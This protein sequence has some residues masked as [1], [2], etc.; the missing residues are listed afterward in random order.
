M[1]W[2]RLVR[3]LAVVLMTGFVYIQGAGTQRNDM[4]AFVVQNVSEETVA[5][6]E[7]TVLE[8]KSVSKER[9]AWGA[10]PNQ[11]GRF[12]RWSVLGSCVRIQ[13]DGHYGSGSIYEMT[14]DQIIIITNRHVLQYWD[15]DSYVTFSNGV[16]CEGEIAKVSDAAD[17][18]LLRIQL[19]ELSE[20][21]IKDLQTIKITDVIPEKGDYF[22]MIDMASDVWDKQLYEG[23]IL[24]SELYIEEFDMEMLYG[25]ACFEPG[26]SG[27][28]IFDMQGNYIG[29]LTGGTQQN[30]VAAVPAWSIFMK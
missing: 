19:T 12:D 14:E 13:T 16:V 5:L 27:C 2:K 15:E 18:G 22:F 20:D 11:E 1:D 30:E 21:E 7:K 24:E 8:E 23:Q 9:F 6:E 26:M 28:G 10:E 29:M 3:V 4:Q 17:V 25:E